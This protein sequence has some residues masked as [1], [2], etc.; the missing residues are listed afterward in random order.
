MR[1]T[2]ATAAGGQRQHH[3]RRRDPVPG[4]SVA[5]ICPHRRWGGDEAV[6][7]DSGAQP[8][9]DR[10]LKH[11]RSLPRLTCPS[12]AAATSIV[13]VAS[14]SATVPMCPMRM[15][16]PAQGPRHAEMMTPRSVI[17]A[18]N[19]RV[20]DTFREREHAE[21]RR[22][23]R[24][25]RQWLES[26]LAHAVANHRGDAAMAFEPD[27]QSLGEDAVER[28]LER[29]DQRH[30][31]CREVPAAGRRRTHPIGA[32]PRSTHGCRRATRGA[33]CARSRHCEDA[34]A[35]AARRALSARR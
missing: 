21:R 30:R 13:R 32:G 34:R 2:A 35:R 33:G 16:R 9:E 20:V 28:D 12:V 18:R 14:A 4:Q 6:I 8:L 26:Q 24:G 11:R 5:G 3:R 27:G 19:V 15:P 17:P 25:M 23:V 22:D 10:G 29:A 1:T 7:T 31:V